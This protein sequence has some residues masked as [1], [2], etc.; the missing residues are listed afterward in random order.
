VS[1]IDRKAGR[2]NADGRSVG[3]ERL[4]RLGLPCALGL[5]LLAGACVPSAGPMIAGSGLGCIGVE[6]APCRS[7][8]DVALAALPGHAPVTYVEVGPPSCAAAPCPKAL[9]PG[10]RLSVV[11]QFA[12]P[13][14]TLVTI[15]GTVDGPL[16]TDAGGAGLSELEPTSAPAPVAGPQPFALAH[17]G[18]GS[19]IDF[20]GSFWDPVG[21]VDIE[22]AESFNGNEGA[23]ILA[24]PDT[25]HYSTSTGFELDLVRH[26]G[27][28]W[29]PGCA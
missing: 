5:A 19:P 20:D 23:I 11:V 7:I 27:S 16:A 2:S 10:Q 9:V 18:I 26:M 12:G 28:K 17:C 21:V 13:P 3:L 8:A 1:P 29:F 22:A 24:S 14:P 15:D 4:S 6:L 25:A